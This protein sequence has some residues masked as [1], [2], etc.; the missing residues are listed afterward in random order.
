MKSAER[1]SKMKW[2]YLI[3]FIAAIS[4][5]KPVFAGFDEGIAAYKKN[6]YAV[7]LLELKPLA[8]AGNPTA[9]S[10]LGFMFAN[11]HGVQQDF[12]EAVKWFRLSA[13]QGDA[14]AQL[15]LGVS[16]HSGEGVPQD[17]KE[18]VKWFRLAAAQGGAIAQFV[19]GVRLN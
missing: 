14:D 6:D 5:A 3:A 16:Y 1:N 10:F 2:R 17:Y 15:K 18:A 9:Q 13:A 11:G 4:M 7:A 12:K 19:L 8:T